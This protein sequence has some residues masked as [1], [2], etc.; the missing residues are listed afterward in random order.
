[1]NQVMNF[2]SNSLR[3][4]MQN[5]NL[6]GKMLQEI[7]LRVYKPVIIYIDNEEYFLSVN[8]EISKES[9]SP[10][11]ILPK[12]I[13]DTLELMSEYSL[14]SYEEELKNGYITIKGGHR[15]GIVGKVVIE[16]NK[17]KTLKN[18]SGLNI[19]ISHQMMGCADKILIHVLNSPSI[20]NTLIVSPPKCGKTTILR[21]I[22][23]QISDGNPE[24]KGLNVSIVDER[25]EIAACFNGMP[26]NDVG[27]RTDVLDG[28]PK[29]WGMRI[30]LRSMSPDVVVVDEIGGEEDAKAIRDILNAGIKV[31][32]SL[33]ASDFEDIKS[34]KYVADLIN[35][36]AFEKIVFLSNKKGMG[37]LDCVWNIANRRWDYKHD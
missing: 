29:V 7:R 28:C 12:D 17:I 33:H 30:L 14:Y 35:E 26:Q 24:F 3:E 5:L 8:G 18:I 34:K 36:K 6:E 11:I 16:N 25:S 2:F 9:I 15:V 10:M 37:T 31:I 21:D 32:C 13:T 22:T 23:R 20:Y 1:M 19:R 27:I 4:R